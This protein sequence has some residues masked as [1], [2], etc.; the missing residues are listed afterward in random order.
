MYIYSYLLLVHGLL[1]PNEN[2]IAVN[3]NNNNNNNNKH[4]KARLGESL[5]KKMEKQSTAWAVH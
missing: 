3:N 5:K 1:S 4:I 2:S